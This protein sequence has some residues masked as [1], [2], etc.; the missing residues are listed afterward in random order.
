MA[1]RNLE[2]DVNYVR[3]FPRSSQQQSIANCGL[4]SK[5]V[6]KP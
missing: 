1:A 6:V 2:V 5:T 3:C 4:P